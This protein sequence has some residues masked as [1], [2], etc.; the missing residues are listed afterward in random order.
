MQCRFSIQNII[1]K[2]VNSTGIKKVKKIVFRSLLGLILLLL[3]L[4]IALSLPFTQTKIAKYFVQRINKDY[5]I[6]IAIDEVAVSVFGG[7]K[8][9]K[10]LILDHHNDTL[11]YTNRIK[12]NVLDGKKLLDGELIFGNIG[13]DGLVFNLKT[14]KKEKITNLDKFI[15][16]FGT[17][18]P[19]SEKHFLMT[20][21]NA[22]ISNGHFILTDENR[23]IPKDV[24]FTK[25]NASISDFKIYG[26][27]VNTM[28]NKMSFLDHRGVFV[29][30]LSSKFSYTK[31]KIRL[32]NLELLTNESTLKA[33]VVLRYKIEDF[34]NFN[35][36]VQ[37]DVKLQSSSIGSN[38][39]R[40]FYKEL[41][42][43]QI[44]FTK[45]LIK[46]T[47][48]DLS[49]KNLKLVGSKNTRI[50]GNLNFI[51]LFGK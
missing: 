5:G 3:V 47:L 13:L 44:F 20:A 31:K 34:K 19:P 49:L 2:K 24:D 10:V 6:H 27:N 40:C 26:P 18:K 17:A 37:F 45:A 39:I 8:L 12:T 38:D 50:N 16:A 35:D 29:K 14:Y 30:N 48:N 9:K 42:K 28:I 33:Q 11:I 1:F 32:E 4:G 51:N 15:D 46:G 21:Q 43:N 23:I 7:V 25:L 36:K 22:A 41:G